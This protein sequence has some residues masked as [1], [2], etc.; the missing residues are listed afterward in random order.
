MK[1]FLPIKTISKKPLLTAKLSI[2]CS[3]PL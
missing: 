3:M 2:L 1:N